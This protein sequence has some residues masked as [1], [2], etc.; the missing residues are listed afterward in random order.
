MKK[1]F[2]TVFSSEFIF[3]SFLFS[4][5]LRT[6]FSNLTINLTL[7][8]FVASM[9]LGINKL[10]KNPTLRKTTIY[11][12][13]FLTLLFISIL[14][15]YSYTSSLEY[16]MDKLV[17][18]ALTSWA[19]V[20]V[21]IF[22]KTKESL[23]KFLNI[24]IIV[25][26]IVSFISM[27]NLENTAGD[28]TR[29]G[30]SNS[31]GIA[32]LFG[33]G[34]IILITVR[35]LGKEKYKLLSLV[36]TS[37]TVYVLLQTGSRMPLLS[38]ASSCIL[39]LIISTRLTAGYKTKIK[40]MVFLLS[41]MVVGIILLIANWSKP[42]FYTIRLR[43]E[44]LG[45]YTSGRTERFLAAKEMF[46]SSPVWGKGVGSFSTFYE[47]ADIRSY[48]HNIF[49]ELLSELGLIGFMIF[50]LLIIFSLIGIYRSLKK[51]INNAQLCL[52]ILFFYTLVNA[53][54]S[55]DIN[56]NRILFTFLALG[57]MLPI[58]NTEVI[59]VKNEKI[60]K[61]LKKRKFRLTW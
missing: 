31:I 22:L 2:T 36:L 1:I 41:S 42:Q 52:I 35:L 24:G 29:L 34:A 6:T 10:I 25:T 18:F 12:I 49:L 45:D 21:F 14:L 33:T 5:A 13:T 19:F 17:N 16:G 60:I 38:L 20:G 37:L 28:F 53:N 61:S 4:G 55:G 43:L 11:P 26:V 44:L 9:I 23:Q 27:T 8:L 46:Y 39:A 7:V 47:G 50:S 30:Q 48:P 58:Y 40:S 32:R 15:S 57:C 59:E 54:V 51:G 56:D 3:F